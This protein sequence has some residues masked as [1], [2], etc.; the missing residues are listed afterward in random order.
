MKKIK[1]NPGVRI[2]IFFVFFAI[3][4]FSL[5][6]WQIERGQ[7]KENILKEFENNITKSPTYLNKDSNKWDRVFVEGTWI[8]SKQIYI[9]NV[10]YGGMAGYKVLTPLKIK[11]TNELILVDRG[12]IKQNEYRGNLPDISINEDSVTVTGILEL[13]ELGLV[14]SDNIVTDSW[15]KVSQT[16]NLNV[17]ANEYNQT[18]YPMI[19]LADP[20][21]KNSL[22]YIKIVPT[23]MTP[24]KH[25]GYSAQWF[26]MF[27]VLCFMYVFYGFRRNA[28]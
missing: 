5:G 14:L 19:L 26:L 2:T 11:E 25:Y 17:L 3:L 4:F 15:P 9:D 21:L 1:F 27:S 10:I 6:L 23:N 24:V 16:K 28:K 8:S 13:P 20:V 12:W 7:S 22:E 18:I